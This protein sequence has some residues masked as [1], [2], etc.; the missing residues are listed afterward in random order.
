MYWISN[1]DERSSAIDL[2]TCDFHEEVEAACME[3]R[4]YFYMLSSPGT[5]VATPVSEEPF[6]AVYRLTNM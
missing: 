6:S 3:W 4:T 5:C 2:N 1:E